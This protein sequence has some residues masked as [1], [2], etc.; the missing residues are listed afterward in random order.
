MKRILLAI[1]ASI[2]LFSCNP[3]AA[4]EPRHVNIVAIGFSYEGNPHG[5]GELV[6]GPLEDAEYMLS[7][8]S[9][10]A[11]KAGYETESYHIT[12]RNGSVINSDTGEEM[13]AGDI[14]SLISSLSADPW[15]LNIFYY[16]GHG[17]YDENY[18]SLMMLPNA[19]SLRLSDIAAMLG[20]TGGKSVMIIDACQSGG[21]SPNDV[22]SGE[23]YSEMYLAD[24]EVIDHLVSISP[25]QAIGDAFNAS[26]SVSREYGD[27]YVLSACTPPQSSFAG[28]E[29]DPNSM[30]TSVMLSYLGYDS[31]TGTSNLPKDKEVTFSSI[32]KSV[33]DNLMRDTMDLGAGTEE[34]IASLQTPQPTRIPTD[35]VLFRF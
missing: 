26:F 27:V 13:T 35:L 32:Y 15:D 25:A 3:D 31:S 29:E 8:L 11:D 19:K 2:L 23:I 16:S 9:F 18:G 30:F 6:P 20:K 7:H 10:L 4:N 24:G 33:M 21:I 22:G 17:F 5:I 14:R 34:A 28:T 1:L 12:D